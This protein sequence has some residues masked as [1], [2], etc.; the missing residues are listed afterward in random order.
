MDLR[1]VTG[2]VKEHNEPLH[3]LDFVPAYE[4]ISVDISDGEVKDI[5][6]HDGSTLRLRKLHRGYDP[7]N[8]LTALA[9]LSEAQQRGEVLTGVVYVEI[10]KPTL[11]DLLNLVDKPLATLPESKVRLAKEIL[12]QLMDEFR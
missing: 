8:K 6:L 9:V 5:K 4:E 10:G 2:Y 7:T 11:L 12:D 1:R 3:A